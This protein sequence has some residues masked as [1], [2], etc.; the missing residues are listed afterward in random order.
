MCLFIIIIWSLPPYFFL[1]MGN[2]AA[3]NTL[4]LEFD[5]VIVREG[6][7][8]YIQFDLFTFSLYIHWPFLCSWQVHLEV[9]YPI[10]FCGRGKGRNVLIVYT[11]SNNYSFLYN[12]FTK[13]VAC[14]LFNVSGHNRL[15]KISHMLENIKNVFWQSYYKTIVMPS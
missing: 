2:K 3:L 12:V 7:L 13:K 9:I 8:F 4:E 1:Q 10:H 11:V 5:S 6:F 15:F 14:F